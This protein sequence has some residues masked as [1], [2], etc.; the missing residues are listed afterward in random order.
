MAYLISTCGA[1]GN[2]WKRAGELGGAEP[3]CSK[4]EGRVT[5]SV[6]DQ[7]MENLAAF[8]PVLAKTV[9]LREIFTEVVK[10]WGFKKGDFDLNPHIPIQQ[11]V[12]CIVS[13]AGMNGV[14]TTREEVMTL[15]IVELYA[16]SV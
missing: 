5:A 12:Q 4:C 15:W 10:Q 16:G 6:L 7:G 13:L 2:S 1:C 8:D 3:P 11:C 9:R 14:E